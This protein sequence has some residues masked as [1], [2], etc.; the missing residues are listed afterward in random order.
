MAATIPEMFLETV[1]GGPDGVALRWKDG[2]TVRDV[3]FAAYAD[4]ASRVAAGLQD[5]GVEHGDR[6]VILMR[7]RPEFHVA[8]VAT[9]LL[10]ATPISV[11][12]SSSAEQLRHL[13]GHCRASV[14]IVEDVEF[15]ARVLEVQDDLPAL[16]HVVIVDDSQGLDAGRTEATPPSARLGPA[17]RWRD[18]LAR[19]PLDLETAAGTAQPHDLATVI[20]TSG[21]TGLPK[22]VMLDHAN[23]CWTVDSLR[24][25]L[26]FSPEGFRI[27]S[28]L[29]MAHIAERMTTHYSGIALGYEVT[30]CPDI[31]LL[32][33]YLNETRP[34]LL[35]GVPRTYEKIHSAVRAFLATDADRAAAF[36]QALERGDDEVLRPVRQLLGLDAVECA[37]TAAAPIPVEVL[38]FFRALGIPLSE[39]YG[40]SESSGPVTWEPDDVRVG[41]VG[42]AIPRSRVAPRS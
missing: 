3:T 34:Q 24:H 37:V 35:F 1:R 19:D 25:A 13:V 26:G 33:S 41:T 29:P 36:D 8:D 17:T 20:Y 15:L 18:L 42:R 28:Y 5:L 27:V 31:R 9:M 2:D 16:E 30:T 14:A 11:Y 38:Q 23:V 32:G 22:G 4:A 39:M 6:V 7:N 12:N 40:L 21:T 10:G